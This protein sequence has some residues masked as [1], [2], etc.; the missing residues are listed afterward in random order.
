MRDMERSLFLRSRLGEHQTPVREVKGRKV[1]LAPKKSARLPPMQPTC[2]H[3]VNEEPQ[4]ALKADCNALANAAKFK[5]PLV[6]CCRYRRLCGTKKK[7]MSDSRMEQALIK[8]A[9]LQRFYVNDD[10]G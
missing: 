3:Q 2:N 5:Y 8:N 10:I 6:L 9:P 7:G 4:L 1:P